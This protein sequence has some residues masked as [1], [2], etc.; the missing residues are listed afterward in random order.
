MIISSI[1]I[2]I[3]LYMSNTHLGYGKS[4]FINI[5]IG[6]F[7]FGTNSFYFGYKNIYSGYMVG[8][9]PEEMTLYKKE[10]AYRYSAYLILSAGFLANPILINLLHGAAFGAAFLVVLV[11]VVA[12][13]AFASVRSHQMHERRNWAVRRIITGDSSSRHVGSESVLPN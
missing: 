6:F 3:I 13:F 4:V 9:G 1:I 5:S 10:I 8:A 12:G 11:P 2:A 7:V